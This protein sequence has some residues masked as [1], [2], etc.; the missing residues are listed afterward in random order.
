MKRVA[1]LFVIALL[2]CPFVFGQGARY[3]NF[4]WQT[5][6][7]QGSNVFTAAPNA[8]V[9]ICSHPAN[10]VPCTN[11]ASTYTDIGLG[12][13]CSTA[14][15]LVLSGSSTCV[16][17]SDIYGSFGFWAN[18]GAYDYTVTT[19]NGSFGPYYITLGVT[20]SAGSPTG[21][22]P[23]AVTAGAVSI[24]NSTPANIT[25]TLGT[26]V[27]IFTGSGSAAV[28]NDVMVGDT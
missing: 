26:G 19:T 11:Y 28:Q 8:I 13:A 6:Y 15:P 1:L 14:T 17:T 5:V 27:E 20:S 3:D 22:T 4:A 9:N 24:Q 18:P 2:L 23:I 10:A 25:S 7:V 16:A 21:V 12:T